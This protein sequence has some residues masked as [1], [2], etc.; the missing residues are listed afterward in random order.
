MR[1]TWRATILGLLASAALVTGGAAQ[2]DRPSG[3]AQV[4]RASSRSSARTMSTMGRRA[5]RAVEALN[6]GGAAALAAKAPAGEPGEE[7]E[8]GGPGPLEDGGELPGGNQGELSIAI[9]DTGQHVV[10]G[11]NDSRGFSLNPLSVSGF[12]WSDDGGQTFTDGG[13][14]PVTTGTVDLD[15]TILPQVFGDPDVK[16]LG[17][18]NFIYSSIVVVPFG[19]ASSAQT[20]GFHRSTDCGHTWEGPFEIQPATNP[21]GIVDADGN[22]FDAAD[23]EQLDV[24]RLTGRVIMSWTNFSETTEISTTYSDNVLAPTPTWTPRV[25]V[26]GRE[27]DGQAATPRFGPFLSR[28]VYVAWE[29][30]LGPGTG[31][32]SV[33]RSTDNGV[34]FEAPV[35]LD[36][37][38]FEPDQVLGN[39]R[40]HW[41]PTIAVDRSLGP[42]RGTV[43]V[44]YMQNNAH[45]GGDIVVQRSVDQGRSFLRPTFVTARPG[46]DRAQW[47]PW[48]TVNDRTGRVLLFYYDQSV[49]DSGDLT[50]VSYTFSDDG[51]RTWAAQRPLSARTFHAGWGNDTSQPNL[52]DYNQSVVDRG[53]DLLAAYAVTRL[54]G[55]TDGLPSLS[56]T[57]PEPTM[58]RI[59][60]AQQAP[61]TTVDLRGVTA[62][63]RPGSSNS[64]GFLDRGE[65]GQVSFD[66]RNY[67][68]NPLNARTLFSP[69]AFA[70]SLTPDA[71]VLI[72]VTT[73]PTLAPGATATSLSPIVL[74]L[75]PTFVSGQDVTIELTVLSLGGL[76]MRLETTLHT[77]TPLATTLINEPFSVAPGT[78]PAGWNA[79]HGAGGNTVPWTTRT[80]FCGSASNGAFHIN[81]NDGANPSNNGR[82]ER[83]FS[84]TIAVPA[85]SQWAEVE[86]DVC[87]DTEDDPNYNILAYDGAFLR[88]FDATPGHTA[89]SVLAE[90]FASDFTT[91]SL[92]HYPKHLPRSGNPFYFEDM[93][94]WAGDSGGLQHVK[95][96]LN[97]LAG[98]MIQLRFEFTQDEIFTCANVRPGHACGV[99]IDNV[100][101]T[102]FQA[103]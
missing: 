4:G 102:S 54:V 88:V 35:D 13:Q 84:P 11:F 33:A 92:F 24:N 18:C 2:G 96:R 93:S 30:E 7:D 19:T 80:G 12:M 100:K 82:W 17:A 38:F 43:Y 47:F 75:A 101:F 78:L 20:M 68:T 90:A 59:R 58:T 63:D 25:L 71:T 51:G 65:I 77:G 22:P 87:T 23:K 52:G 53:G 89:R 67:V 55:F 103:R 45:D 70:R 40:I 44:A 27:E 29:T 15:G 91:G 6:S 26:G 66:L 61:I 81:A 76:P 48:I 79:V 21:N 99:L 50:Q 98:T 28:L 69:I 97:G 86:L 32:V 10:L 94:V 9:D 83:L 85:D 72:G 74:R 73:F 60:L 3:Q 42:H 37:G 16:Y 41:F 5:R 39:D 8:G 14:L 1:N 64:N 34:S 62:T 46:A 56:M 95:I 31:G 36:P 49:A 57:V